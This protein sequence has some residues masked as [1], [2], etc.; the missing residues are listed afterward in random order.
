[1]KKL[2]LIGLLCVIAV[3][4]IYQII[5][6]PFHYPYFEYEFNVSGKRK[7]KFE[8]L[9]DQYINNRGIG[10]FEE[11]YRKVQQWKYDSQQKLD[12]S[13]LK[14]LRQRQYYECL[15]DE[16]MFQFILTRQQTRYKQVN[17]K[18][19]SY[20]V[21]VQDKIYSCDYQGLINRYAM[22]RDIG[23][24]CTLN[25]YHSKNQRKLMTKELRKRIMIRDNYTCQMC[26]KYM[27]DEVGLHIDH[28][29]PVSKGGKT[30]ESNLQV[31]CSKCNGRK[32]NNL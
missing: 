10:A 14:N 31:L 21:T 32:S 5:T 3:T 23:F 7:P 30:I 13:I 28:I 12:K 4:T 19:T 29:V 9:I 22:L 17:Y 2:I 8:D 16:H 6:S 25:E 18:K 26:G 15:D 27:P 11:H 24:Q 20:K 1:M